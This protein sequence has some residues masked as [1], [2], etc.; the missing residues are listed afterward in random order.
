[1]ESRRR[2]AT[3]LRTGIV[4]DV[5]G[6]AGTPSVEGSVGAGEAPSREPTEEDVGPGAGSSR[7]EDA[8]GEDEEAR[9]LEPIAPRLVGGG[10]PPGSLSWITSRSR[11]T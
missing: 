7:V 1:M 10:A 5:D 11:A 6:A 8:A 4:E 9:V 3:E 2:T